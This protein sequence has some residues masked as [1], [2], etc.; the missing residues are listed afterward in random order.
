MVERRSAVVD[1]E[2]VHEGMVVRSPDGKKL[3][4]VLLC[5]EE[6]F[7]IEK[8]SFSTVDYVAQYEDVADISGGEILL[9]RPRE[10]LAHFV[11]DE[12][13]GPTPE[14]FGDEGGG[15]RFGG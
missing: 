3:G 4:R 12:G 8:H 9:S 5:E 13:T 7:I 14:T 2:E 10:E 1:R 11:Q 6:R 15:G